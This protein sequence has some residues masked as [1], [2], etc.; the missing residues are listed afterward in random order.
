MV[1][2]RP[3]CLGGWSVL[4]LQKKI[5]LFRSES[6]DSNQKIVSM[7]SRG[8]RNNNP[9]NIIKTKISWF[10][11]LEG[12]FS[13]DS[14][15]ESFETL[16]AGIR[17]G[18]LNLKNG[19]QKKGFS[20]PKSLIERYAPSYDNSAESQKGYIAAVAKGAFFNSTITNRVLR[21]REEWLRAAFAMLRFENGYDVISIEELSKI[22]DNEKIFV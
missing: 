10:G 5:V 18:L 6:S 11:K 12:L 8:H 14:K 4:H 20:T 15:F 1:V 19:Y 9:F 7:Q 22:N 16:E 2:S 13:K 21:T 17:A 3:C